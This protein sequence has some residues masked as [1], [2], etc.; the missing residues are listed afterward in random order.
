[1]WWDFGEEEEEIVD[2]Y[3]MVHVVKGEGFSC[4]GAFPIIVMGIFLHDCDRHF[5]IFVINIC[6]QL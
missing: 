6:A 2:L 3:H 1:V 5:P 4:S